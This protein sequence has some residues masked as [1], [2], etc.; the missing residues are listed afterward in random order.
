MKINSYAWVK[1]ILRYNLGEYNNHH[2]DDDYA[3]DVYA[4]ITW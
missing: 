4:N 2:K 1:E 3:V